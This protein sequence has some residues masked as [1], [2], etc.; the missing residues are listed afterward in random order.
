P[1]NIFDEKA[2]KQVVEEQGESK[3]TAAK[4]DMIAHATKKA[5]SERLEQDPAFF[6]KFSKMIQQAIDDFRA[7]RISDLDYLNK[8]TEIKEAVVNRRTDDA[9]AQLGGNDNALALYGVLKPYVLGHVSTEDVAANLAADSA[10]DI[11][12]IIQRNRK[13]GFWDDLDAQRRTMNEID[14]YLYDEVKGNK[15]VQLTTGE[16]DDIIDRTMQLARHRMVG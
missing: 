12:S 5:I 4:A 3:A 9:P 7:K 16:M 8:V 14:D 1:V 13:V 6:E 15:G 10:I 11:W 2:F